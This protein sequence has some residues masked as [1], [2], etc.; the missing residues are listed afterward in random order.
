[1][2]G[3]EE[4]GQLRRVEKTL[5]VLKAEMCRVAFMVNGWSEPTGLAILVRKEVEAMQE[6]VLDGLQAQWVD[7]RKSLAEEFLGVHKREVEE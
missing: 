6:E 2:G 1:M 5:G 4:I 3:D 7:L